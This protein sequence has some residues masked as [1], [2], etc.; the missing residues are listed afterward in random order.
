MRGGDSLPGGPWVHR[1]RPRGPSALQQLVL[2]LFPLPVATGSSQRAA[3]PGAAH[4]AGPV[5]EPEVRRGEGPE[6]RLS[7]GSFDYK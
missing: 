3:R 2:R 6:F 7:M 1:T 5:R 4:R